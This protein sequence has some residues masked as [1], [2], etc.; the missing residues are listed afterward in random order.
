M[1]ED[2]LRT[3]TRQ[4]LI[5][6]RPPLSYTRCKLRVTGGPDAGLELETERD[7]VRVG[8]AKDSDLVLQDPAVSRAHLELRKGRGAYIL[9]D[10]G[11]T[12]GTFV[13][14]LEVREVKLHKSCEVNLGGTTL[15]VEPVVAEVGFQPSAARS[16]GELVGDSLAMR[17]IF[18]IL[19]RIAPTELAVLV[20]G[21]TGTGKDLVARAVHQL[22]RRREGPFVTFSLGA[23]PPALL[24][25]ALFGHE[26]GALEGAEATYPG[27]FERARGGTLFLEELDALPLDL[28]P[29]LLRAIE[30]GEIQ[31]L[32]GRGPVRVDVR[33][34]AAAAVDIKEKVEDGGFRDDLYYRL[35]EIRLD[36]PPLKERVEDIEVIAE[37]FFERHREE[38][39]AT[40]SRARRLGPGALLQ[41]QRYAFPGNVRELINILRRGVAVTTTEEIRASDLPPE[42]TG[43]RPGT[44][45]VVGPLVPQVVVPDSSMRFRDAKTQVLEAFER[46]YLLD[47]LQ[48]HKMQI[49]KAAREAGIDRRHLYRLLEKYNVEIGERQLEE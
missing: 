26:A 24:E 2:E 27:A 14:A 46:Q 29:R 6:G 30:R 23:L 49:A 33:L 47:L 25:S 43:A 18:F 38:L 34:V 10:L 21:E 45:R 15:A 39:L 7:L 17:E 48:R 16:C 5:D 9:V 19:E 32:S 20:T 37:H 36:L 42:V 12:N 35:A 44:A 28:Q 4:A 31:R 3:D 22:G 1:V 8:T 41:L 40:G 13:G 11:S